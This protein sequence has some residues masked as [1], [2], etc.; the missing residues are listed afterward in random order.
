[1][2]I[3]TAT[4]NAKMNARASPP[5]TKGFTTTASAAAPQ[6]TKA[7]AASATKPGPNAAATSINIA[8][9]TT[10]ILMDDDA[11]TSAIAGY[12]VYGEGYWRVR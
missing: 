2:A 10:N 7:N 6:T 4:A 1:M 11:A 12:H 8:T 5:A 3:T 9:A